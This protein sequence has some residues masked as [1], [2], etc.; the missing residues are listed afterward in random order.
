MTGWLLEIGLDTIGCRVDGGGWVA[1]GA[2]ACRIVPADDDT[3]TVEALAKNE[4]IGLRFFAG[5]VDRGSPI[6]AID[7]DGGLFVFGIFPVLLLFGFPL[8]SVL[9]LVNTPF[10]SEAPRDWDTIRVLRE[11]AS[12]FPESPR[13][14][15]ATRDVLPTLLSPE[16]V[17][18]VV[19][20]FF[21]NS[22]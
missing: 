16:A 2:D 5:T 18:L 1:G 11:I 7:D 15:E 9:L 4:D 12:S 17:D 3:D 13:D 22:S 21:R 20:L 14:D 6:S 8:I 19:R 10:L